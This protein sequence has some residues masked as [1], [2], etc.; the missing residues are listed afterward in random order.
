MSGDWAAINQVV[1]DVLITSGIGVLIVRQFV[2]RTAELSRMLWMPVIVIAAGLIYLAVELRAGFDWM[3]ADWLV[4][5]ELGMVAITGTAMGYTTRFRN[6]GHRLQYRL[7][8][9]GVLLW[10]IFVA[11]RVGNFALAGTLGANLADATGLILLS[12][13]VNR[14]AAITVVRHRAQAIVNAATPHH[15]K[16]SA[17]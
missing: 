3:A 12:F 10:T 16:I 7:T 8:G 5:A 6:K 13:G 1:D 14:L 17:R 11:I 2:W 9:I 15:E 4:V